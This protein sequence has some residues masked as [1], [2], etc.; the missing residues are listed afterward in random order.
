[1]GKITNEKRLLEQLEHLKSA[2]DIIIAG[3]KNFTPMELREQKNGLDRAWA[4]VARP[5]FHLIEDL[6]SKLPEIKKEEKK[7]MRLAK[8]QL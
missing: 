2:T 3:I 4:E 5:F 1:M 7:L 6:E 8:T